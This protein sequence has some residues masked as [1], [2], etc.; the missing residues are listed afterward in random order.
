MFDK[1]QTYL[2]VDLQA[3]CAHTTLNW[4]ALSKWWKTRIAYICNDMHIIVANFEGKWKSQKLKLF[5]DL[6]EKKGKSWLAIAKLKPL[7]LFVSLF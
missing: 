1:V 2:F 6:M 7:S 5:D 3:A 4:E